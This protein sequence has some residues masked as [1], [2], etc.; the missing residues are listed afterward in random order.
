MSSQSFGAFLKI[1]NAPTI[2]GPP[3]AFHKS[4]HQGLDDMPVA[5]ELDMVPPN[6]KSIGPADLTKVSPAPA[7][8]INQS[9]SPQA[10]EAVEALQSFSK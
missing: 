3:A 2:S 5:H 1:E 4:S 10:Y 9:S 6:Q 8:A 7:T